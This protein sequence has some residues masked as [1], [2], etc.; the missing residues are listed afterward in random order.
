[1]RILLVEDDFMLGE[2]YLAGLQQGAYAVDWV[3]S[4]EDAVEALDLHTYD[5]ILLDLGLP[6]ADGVE[7]LKYIRSNN[8]ILPVLVMTARDETNDKVIVLDNGADDYLVKPVDLYELYARIRAL[9]RR[10]QPKV[11]NQY[12]LLNDLKLDLSALKCWYKDNLVDLSAKEFRILQKLL[13]QKNKLV[14]KEQLE[15]VLYSWGHEIE[16]NAIEV[17]IYRIR[18]KT[19]KSL[20]KTIRAGGYMIEENIF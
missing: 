9:S 7:F 2:A 6:D 14:S 5:L 20:I 13:D 3:Q 18:K 11:Q 12:M 1:M 19:D 17:H 8:F 15:G 16:S 10:Q 4:M